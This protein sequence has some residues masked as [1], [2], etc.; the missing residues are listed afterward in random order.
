[1][2]FL[3]APTEIAES[4]IVLQCIDFIAFIKNSK[5]NTRPEDT[6]TGDLSAG[7]KTIEP[8][9]LVVNFPT[10]ARPEE[11]TGGDLQTAVK[12]EMSGNNNQ[13][14]TKEACCVVI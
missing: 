7:Q 13:A 3:R 9:S 14:G 6:K 12:A 5:K 8:N 1:M 2:E 10:A 4:T 11:K